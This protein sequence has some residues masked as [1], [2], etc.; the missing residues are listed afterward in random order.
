[1]KQLTKTDFILYR[2]CAK[3]VWVKWH[4]PEEYKKFPISE[5]EE[6]LG[7]MGNE[8]EKLARGMF[9][10]GYLVEKR[11]EGAQELTKKLMLVHTP[12]I[13]QAVFSTDK[14]LAATDVLKWNKEAKA[15]DLY[16]IKMSSTEG[17][18]EEVVER[19]YY[20]PFGHSGAW[21]LGRG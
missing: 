17:E 10:D 2:E 5:F 7:V 13:F 8:V 14:Y 16:E 9:P 12:I 3:N 1:M 15:Y 21:F 6:S 11:S 4:M 19:L 20:K 18:S